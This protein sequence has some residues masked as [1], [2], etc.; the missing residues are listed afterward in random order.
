VARRDGPVDDGA[1]VREYLLAEAVDF[2]RDMCDTFLSGD[3]AVEYVWVELS[4]PVDQL[5]NGEAYRLH[6]WE[7]PDDHPARAL[8]MNVDFVLGADDVLRVVS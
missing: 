5:A 1:A 2:R 8:G 7:L 4:K 6:G 3:Q